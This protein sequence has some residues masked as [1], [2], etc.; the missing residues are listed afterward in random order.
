MPPI[1]SVI[2]H[3]PKRAPGGPRFSTSVLSAAVRASFGSEMVSRTMYD[4]ATSSGSLHDHSSVRLVSVAC[5][6]TLVAFEFVRCTRPAGVANCASQ[7]GVSC[8]TTERRLG[9]PLAG[10]PTNENQASRALLSICSRRCA[11]ESSKVAP[12]G[13]TRSTASM[14]A[15][16]AKFGGV[17]VN[18]P[19]DEEHS[20][21]P[22]RRR[23]V[24]CE[25]ER[26]SAPDP[27]RAQN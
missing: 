14:A 2:A 25:R 1:V 18:A 5:A 8:G 16:A 17:S 13:A 24:R 15:T 10:A 4:T 6:A 21:G 7:R 9:A 11:F 22:R 23:R 20:E 3:S 12:S 19:E 27:P 26:T